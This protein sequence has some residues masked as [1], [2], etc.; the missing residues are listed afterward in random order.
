LITLT[1]LGEEFSEYILLV[2]SQKLKCLNNLI[3]YTQI[4]C[5]YYNFIEFGV[6]SFSYIYI[7]S[8]FYVYFDSNFFIG[9]KEN[10]PSKIWGF[11]GCEYEDGCLLGCSTV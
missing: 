6:V 10:I 7:Y 2:S 1:I 5:T 3:Y 4:Q 9:L 11:H 8:Y